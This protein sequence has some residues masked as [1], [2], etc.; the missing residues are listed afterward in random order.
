MSRK[1][2]LTAL[3]TL[4]IGLTVVDVNSQ[5]QTYGKASWYHE[6]QRLASGGNFDP[7]AMTVAHRTLP[8][9]T[10]VKLTNLKNGLHAF[11]VVNDRGPA[12][13]LKG[14]IVDASRA[15][16]RKLGMLKSGVV[17]IKMEVVTVPVQ[18][19][20]VAQVV[21]RKKATTRTTRRVKTQECRS[22][23][24]RSEKDLTYYNMQEAL[25]AASN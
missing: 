8:F 25:I 22:L 3:I 21:P 20:A 13:R 16:A 1:T 10:W 2:S 18:K 19:P 17:P 12:K 23:D 9:G 14:R 4:V 11:A 24:V 6:R 7:D 5:A 15:V